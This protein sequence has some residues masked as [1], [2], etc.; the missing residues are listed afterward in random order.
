MVTGYFLRLDERAISARRTGTF[1][2]YQNQAGTVKIEIS[3]APCS[4][5]SICIVSVGIQIH[6]TVLVMR[7]DGEDMKV[8]KDGQLQV[9]DDEISITNTYT[10]TRSNSIHYAING[11]SNFQLQVV[12][13]G[14]HMNLFLKMPNNNCNGASGICGDC[15]NAMNY[16]IS[17]SQVVSNVFNQAVSSGDSILQDTSVTLAGYAVY[18]DGNAGA[19]SE[20][21][22]SESLTSSDGWMTFHFTIYI[23]TAEGVLFTYA[24]NKVFAIILV[25]GFVGFQYG[26]DV[27][28]TDFEIL[29]NEWIVFSMAYEIDTGRILLDQTSGSTQSSWMRYRRHY[30]TY[31]STFYNLFIESGRIS[32]G[33]WQMTDLNI[34]VPPAERFVGYIDRLLWW[35]QL[36]GLADIINI[37]STYILRQNNIIAIIDF[38]EGY[39]TYTYNR[40][41][42]VQMRV[43]VS[44]FY[45][46]SADII[47]GETSLEVSPEALFSRES[48]LTV[49]GT[50]CRDHFESITMSSD[51]DVARQFFLRQCLQAVGETGQISSTMESFIMFAF[52]FEDISGVSTTIDSHC[53]EFA[54]ARYTQYYG[55]N[56]DLLCKY[57]T[58]DPDL[59][60]CNCLSFAYGDQCDNLSYRDPDT[61]Y[62]C[63]GHGYTCECS[64]ACICEDNWMGDDVCS[65]CTAGQIGE[66]CS[67]TELTPPA[68]NTIFSCSYTTSGLGN[69]RGIAFQ[70]QSE[71]YW[72]LLQA[73]FLTV[74]VSDIN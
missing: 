20:R 2:F 35:G 45:L 14:T 61:G 67:L 46:S 5:F 40:V 59:Q 27:L 28:M 4:G 32:L 51:Y 16:Q 74:T 72:T 1:T 17:Q 33:L 12:V 57:G 48:L 71:P 18:L 30:S 66:D 8:Y 37:R 69:M 52:L 50:T 43:P 6:S 26:D 31:D 19:I 65:L 41:D 73:G 39:G 15:D 7:M 21:F 25:D 44:S 64:G 10:F 22:H 60:R 3:Q 58:V 42:G 53:N 11:P 36:M 23:E 24:V 68:D 13:I 63:S 56:C 55:E 34:G 62:V 49:T 54:Y 9:Y 38:D 29:T 70:P 47:G